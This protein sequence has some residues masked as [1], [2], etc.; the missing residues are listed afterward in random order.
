MT[1]LVRLG[2]LVRVRHGGTPSKSN[3]SFWQGNIPWVSPKDFDGDTLRE[4]QD[5]ISDEA[6]SASAACLVPAGTVLAVVRSG[7]LAHSFPVALARQPLSFNQD[8]KALIP[9]QQR[10]L[11]Q[12]LHL[13]LRAAEKEIVHRGVKRGATVHSMQ[14]GFLESM[15]VRLPHLDEQRRI[16]EILDRAASVRRL[17]CQAQDTAGQL[18]PALFNKMFGDPAT[19][20]MGWPVVAMRALLRERPRYGTMVPAATDVKPYL[21]IRVANIQNNTIDLRS[22]KYVPLHQIDLERHVVA[23]GDLLIARAIASRAHLGKCF[24]VF[25]ESCGWFWGS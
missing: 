20:P 13:F 5:L 4:P 8:I 10:I 25:R 14:A 24:G 9:D 3:Q 15:L 1:A 21:C 7:V 6:L 12:F 22:K 2:E 23:D 16:V 11:P 19:N 18:I 17:R